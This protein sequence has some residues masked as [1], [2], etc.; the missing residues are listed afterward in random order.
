MSLFSFLRKSKRPE[1][2]VAEI[3]TDIHSHFIPAIDD[4]AQSMEE[5]LD[6]LREMQSLGY[7]KVITTPHT[8]TNSF[9]NT[10]EIILTGLEKVR[11][12]IEKEEDLNIE[13][14]AATEYYLDESFLDR[15]E[16]K[17]KLLTFGDNY[18][19]VETGF[20]NEA[21][22][23]KEASFL[24]TMQGYKMVLAHPERYLYLIDNKTLLEDLLD[25]D[26]ILQLNIVALTGC[27]SKP[28]QKFAESLIDMEAVKLAGS[29]CHNMGH[30]ELMKQARNSKYWKK[31]LQLDL[32]NNSL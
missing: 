17:E 29:D 6:L 1:K 20:M 12:A 8:M 22:E 4:G 11:S 13:I 9:D 2:P 15:L 26:I 3:T 25:R 30:I 16:N 24:M 21:P 7:K 5:T 27:Y 19:L 18:V 31:L 10:P 28:V 32:L 23:L 14:E